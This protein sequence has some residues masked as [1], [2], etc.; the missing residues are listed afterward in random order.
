MVNKCYHPKPCLLCQC[1]LWAH[2][3]GHVPGGVWV[4]GVGHL[5]MMERWPRPFIKRLITHRQDRCGFWFRDP[6]IQM[7]KRAAGIHTSRCRNGLE[8]QQGPESQVTSLG[9]LPRKNTW[10]PI[11]DSRASETEKSLYLGFQLFPSR[12]IALRNHRAHLVK[13]VLW[14]GGS[15]SLTKPEHKHKFVCSHHS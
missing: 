1:V 6:S 13:P 5:H 15:E 14:E 9:R 10:S 11:W 12:S 7:D 4:Q 8:D 3:A 2:T